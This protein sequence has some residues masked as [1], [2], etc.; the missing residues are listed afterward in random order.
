MRT[1]LLAA[2]TILIVTEFAG[3]QAPADSLP[4]VTISLDE[5]RLWVLAPAG[6][7]L[8]SAKVAVGSGTL[9][10]TAERAWL[11]QTPTGETH[12]VAKQIAPLWVPPDWH[13][14]EVAKKH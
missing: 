11:F 5:R 13:Y 7:T 2:A 1:R 10:R 3:G 8:F 4:C 6:D 12:V 9:L 14:M